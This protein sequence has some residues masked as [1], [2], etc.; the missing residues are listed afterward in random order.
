MDYFLNINYLLDNDPT[1]ES[2]TSAD[3]QFF[4][5]SG[6]HQ[7]S[8]SGELLLTPTPPEEIPIL[9]PPVG[10]LLTP[11]GELLLTPVPQ[12]QIPILAPPVGQ[13][14]THYGLPSPSILKNIEDVIEIS[15]LEDINEDEIRK[16]GIFHL[17]IK[18][19]NISQINTQLLSLLLLNSNYFIN[20]NILTISDVYKAN[21]TIYGHSGSLKIMQVHEDTEEQVILVVKKILNYIKKIFDNAKYIWFKPYINYYTFLFKIKNTPNIQENIKK[22]N[23]EFKEKKKKNIIIKAK[24]KETSTTIN[25]KISYHL[26]APRI[27][28][29]I[30]EYD[31]KD[32]NKYMEKYNKENPYKKKENPYKEEFD[33][34]KFDKEKEK[35]EKEEE[36]Y[37]NERYDTIK[38]LLYIDELVKFFTENVKTKKEI[39]SD[40]AKV[41]MRLKDIK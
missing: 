17:M 18:P 8:P 6:G 7:L 35:Y 21:I 22:L 34:E 10:Q 26:E 3:E 25:I 30:R 13:L 41:V 32:I 38:H 1:H 28:Y 24:I 16:K 11:S 19:F 12:E 29:D 15:T 9:A 4:P 40:I 37:N 36:K 23:E 14:L 2:S 5:Y 20:H 39:I 31:K 27:K 33:K